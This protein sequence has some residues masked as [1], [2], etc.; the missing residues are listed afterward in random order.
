MYTL[1]QDVGCFV[2]DIVL[3][4]LLLAL[5]AAYCSQNSILAAPLQSE[6]SINPGLSQLLFVA[7]SLQQCNRA[8]YQVN[9]W[10]LRQV[11]AKGP[12]LSPLIVGNAVARHQSL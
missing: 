4:C 1:D 8:E 7:S 11:Q 6:R 2:K 12:R 5:I 9:T 3:S 10:I